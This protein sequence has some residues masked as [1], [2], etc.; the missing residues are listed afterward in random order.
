[1]SICPVEDYARKVLAG[2]IVAGRLV[3]LA[4]AR[5]LR[6]LETGGERGLVWDG[7]AAARAIQFVGL[8]M[9]P[10]G[11][12]F[13]LEP[14]QAFIVGCLFGWKGDDGFRR[15]RTAY[16]EMGKGGGKSPLAA[17]VG[18]YGL[19]ADGEAAAEVYSAAVTRE[20][21]G[22][23]FR[24]A[25]LMV[26]A[27]VVLRGRLVNGQNNISFPARAAFFRPVSSEHRG[28]DGKRPHVVLIDEVHEHP[29]ALVVDKMRAGTKGR[30]QA[31]IFEITN[32]GYDRQSVCW[33]HHTYSVQVLEGSLE[34]DT[35]FAYVCGLD[36]CEACLDAGKDQPTDGCAA[37]DQWTDEAVWPKA[38]PGLG[39]ILTYKYLREQVQEALGM[40]SKRNLVLRLNFC[41]WTQN[42][43]RAIAADKWAA[44]STATEP[45]A[46]R[47]AMRER[48]KGQTCY[49]G[50]DLG[51]TSDL[52]AKVLVFPPAEG[53]WILLPF[54][55]VPTETARI[56][57]E[58]DQVNY[59]LWIEQGFILPTEGDTTD[60]DQIRK[61]CNE[62][63]NWFGIVEVGVDR[64]FQGA[65]LC[66]QLAADGFNVI[67]FAQSFMS[68]AAPVKRFLELIAAGQI[69][70]G[71]N[72]VLT[73]MAGNASLE[74]D[75]C[76]NQKF[77]K[78]KS[79]EKIDGL[80]AAV[81]GL[82]R[83]I[84]KGADGGGGGGAEF[85]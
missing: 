73:W 63:A 24:D 9:L 33:A 3:R 68:M 26:E 82:A 28:L 42:E 8:L 32:S 47:E 25:K 17:A 56:R 6:D 7:A 55:W 15:F 80:V 38:N 36:V 66:T 52:C 49:G 75:V 44:C 60:Y 46:W 54:F 13:V 59:P 37:C 10:N 64:L 71:G 2:E 14:F 43:T 53:P 51:S 19:V 23:L 81:M 40:P 69:D 45:R 11:K 20:Q 57:S 1:M 35:W 18:L 21:A 30:R 84:E 76:G 79:R 31:L 12:A 34:N 77:S 50:L 39:S 58:R 41:V 4:C 29:N 85:W 62:L 74:E 72:P 22:I 78:R 48:L 5:H 65:Q 83:A 67:A 61:D 16:I 27:S 70:H